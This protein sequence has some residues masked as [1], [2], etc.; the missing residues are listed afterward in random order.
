MA[1]ASASAAWRPPATLSLLT[2]ELTSLPSTDRSTAMTGMSASCTGV[3]AAAAVISVFAFSRLV[4]A[5]LSGTVVGRFGE[6]RVFVGPVEVAKAAWRRPS[7]GNT[8]TPSKVTS[9]SSGR[10][11]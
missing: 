5:P 6:L 1:W 7:G 4:F 9:R 3:T 8:P 11:T 2:V 10:V